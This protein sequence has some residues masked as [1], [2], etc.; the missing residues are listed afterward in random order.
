MP[1]VNFTSPM[2]PLVIGA[3]GLDSV[4]QNIRII[5]LTLAYSVAL[6]RGF[7]NTGSFI[8][9]PTPYAVARKIAELTEAIETREPRAKVE[10]IRFAAR[11]TGPA[12][13]ATARDS[14]GGASAERASAD[15]RRAAEA[16]Q[17]A[18]AGRVYPIITFS[19]RQGV[20]S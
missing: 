3:S 11:S 17:E 19:I 18:M 6:D 15:I 1:E 4:T 5:V 13:R 20:E 10:N 16:G 2:P 12:G 8:D 7:A 9:A 14:A